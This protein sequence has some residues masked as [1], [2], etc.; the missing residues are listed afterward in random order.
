MAQE[1]A[2]SVTF[3]QC[4]AWLAPATIARMAFASLVD[5]PRGSWRLVLYHGSLAPSPVG[6]DVNSPIRCIFYDGQAKMVPRQLLPQEWFSPVKHESLP[7]PKA[8]SNKTVLS[9][10]DSSPSRSRSSTP[11]QRRTK[12]SPPTP[13]WGFGSRALTPLLEI[14]SAR[15]PSRTLQDVEKPPASPPHPFEETRLTHSPKPVTPPINLDS[16][17]QALIVGASPTQFATIEQPS[18]TS[19]ESQRCSTGGGTSSSQPMTPST[20]NV[21][22][23]K[24]ALED[25]ESNSLSSKRLKSLTPNPSEVN[26]DLHSPVEIVS[27]SRHV[28]DM[29]TTGA[30]D[31]AEI[32]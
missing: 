23:S 9:H 5:A 25:A 18:A 19:H 3:L 32:G 14:P 2:R 12:K 1:Y 17:P 15:S 30:P 16:H 27:E 21:T 8:S 29:I 4:A 11:T 28:L 10:R 26:V 22:S 24:R 31:K 6:R 7:T 20:V 13:S